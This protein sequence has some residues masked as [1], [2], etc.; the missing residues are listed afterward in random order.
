MHVFSKTV[1]WPNFRTAFTHTH[2]ERLLNLVRHSLCLSG[3]LQCIQQNIALLCCTSM[4]ACEPFKRSN[5][6]TEASGISALLLDPGTPPVGHQNVPSPKFKL[7]HSK[8][9]MPVLSSI[10][11]LVNSPRFRPRTL[12]IDPFV[13]GAVDA[14][15]HLEYRSC[16]P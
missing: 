4:Q 10:S 5:T 9:C 16:I 6:A 12:D 14:I 8:G 13:L 7:L 3:L 2:A 1:P 15:L 11:T